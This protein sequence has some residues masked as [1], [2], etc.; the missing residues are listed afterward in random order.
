MLTGGYA[1]LNQKPYMTNLCCMEI[2]TG[3]SVYRTTT[4]HGQ[5]NG[6]R[7]QERHNSRAQACRRSSNFGPGASVRHYI[8]HRLLVRAVKLAKQSSA[9]L[10]MD[11]WSLVHAV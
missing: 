9:A 7:S 1:D 2:A 5:H 6:G 3:L 11:E 8:E 4:P 10:F